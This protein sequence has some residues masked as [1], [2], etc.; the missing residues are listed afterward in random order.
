MDISPNTQAI[1]LLTAPLIVGK[2]A[3]AAPLLTLTD[4]NRLAR[5]LREAGQEP[6][7]LLG[8]ESGALLDTCGARFGRERLEALLA[9]GFQLSHAVDQWHSR[10][11]WVISRADACYPRRLKNRLR[12]EAPPILYGCGQAALLDAGGLAVVGSRHVDDELISYTTRIG[13]LAAEAGKAIVSGAARGIDSSAMS[14][15]IEAGG[16]VVGVMADSLGRAA[17]AKGNREAFREG[18]LVVIS[19]YDPAAGFNVGHAMQRNKAIYALAD[20]ALVVTSDFNKGGTWAGAIEQLDRLRFVPVFVRDGAKAGKGNAAL[21]QRG[22]RAWPDPHSGDALKSTLAAAAED[23]AAKPSQATLPL[24]MREESAGYQSGKAAEATEP[25]APPD[26]AHKPPTQLTPEAELWH[27]VREILRR[28][29]G[30]A[31]TEE[32]VAALLVV[33]KPQAKAWLTRM[34]QEGLAEK[35]RKS[36]PASYRAVS[37]G[38]RLL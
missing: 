16:K 25:V 13:S 32:E 3:E 20:A 2:K 22:G 6:A 15:A 4:Y 12:E 33:A 19:A 21:L 29:L 5:C 18:R 28:E 24:T 14:G 36:K 37:E 38:E 30:H 7:D 26:E 31:L 23:V 34:V 27:T 9:R 35:V 8:P 10:G 1:L 17:L 11:I